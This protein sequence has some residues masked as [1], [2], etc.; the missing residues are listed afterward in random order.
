MMILA[1]Y[2]Y[3]SSCGDPPNVQNADQVGEWTAPLAKVHQRRVQDD[4]EKAYPIGA[5]VHYVC[6]IGHKFHDNTTVRSTLC[7]P[8]GE[9]SFIGDCEGNIC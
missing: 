9:W 6:K 4:E 3:T 1:E 8:F 5:G 7:M 2:I